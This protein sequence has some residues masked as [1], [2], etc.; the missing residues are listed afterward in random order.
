MNNIQ[1]PGTMMIPTDE[2]FVL[3]RLAQ[4][5]PVLDAERLWL[6]SLDRRFADAMNK[7]AAQAK[8]SIPP[9]P[10]DPNTEEAE[11]KRDER[12]AKR[13]AERA[14]ASEATEA[15]QSEKE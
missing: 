3:I 9:E 4:R 6:N 1:P 2:L 14:A 10:F 11:T 7:F 13:L 12:K 8:A 5:A 15:E